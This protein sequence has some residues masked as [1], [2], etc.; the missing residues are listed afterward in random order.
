NFLQ[1]RTGNMPGGSRHAP[2]AVD[3]R[4]PTFALQFKGAQAATEEESAANPRARSAKLRAAV[5]TSAPAWKLG[6]GRK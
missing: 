6:G 2:V 1:E 5:R 3:T 4:Q